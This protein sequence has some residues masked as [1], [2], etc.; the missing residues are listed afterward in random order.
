[1]EDLDYFKS[2]PIIYLFIW[3]VAI[4]ESSPTDGLLCFA[5]GVEKSNEAAA[6]KLVQYEK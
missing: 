2:Y 4:D 5:K 3:E 1:L 6:S